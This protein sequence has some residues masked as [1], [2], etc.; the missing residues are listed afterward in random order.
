V[1]TLTAWLYGSPIVRL[2][3]ARNGQ[4]SIDHWYPEA[5]ERWGAGSPMMSLSMPIGDSVSDSTV[6]NFFDNL[7]PE[8]RRDQLAATLGLDRPTV[9]AVLESIGRDCAGAISVLD[10]AVLPDDLANEPAGSAGR[11]LPL[12]D[13]ELADLIRNL[14]RRPLGL[15]PTVRH[16]L[17]GV[18]GKLLLARTADG[19]WAQ[20]V[21]GEPSTH[22]LKPEP[23]DRPFG[24]AGNELLCTRLARSCGLTAVDSEM[25]DVKG[26]SVFVTS[27]FDRQILDD[28]VRRIHQEDLCQVFG[29]PAGAK[30]EVPGERLFTAT[31][32][33]LR[34]RAR[35]ADVV[36][37][38][39]MMT[40]NVAIGNTDA[41]C[42]NIAVLHH[43]DTTIALAPVYDV[44]RHIGP[45][46]PV[47]LGMSVNGVASI[48]AV[49]AGDLV[50]EIVTWKA[51]INERAARSIVAETLTAV[52]GSVEECATGVWVDEEIV[53]S[54]HSGADELL[55]TL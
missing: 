1:R 4:L 13:D 26:R 27:R 18:Q 29:R 6:T 38:A 15:G 3:E 16:S 44:A 41:H 22:I 40:F 45:G 9:F 46:L 53:D 14:P 25:L 17:A 51:R 20:P 54:I 30:Y 47:E 42:K 23:M 35:R 39:Q 28:G 55:S 36:R 24:D 49:T 48:L 32:S 37:L 21:G 5:I 50:E 19:R 11:L 2:V 43:S 8:V 12:S 33:I 52:R 10:A 7:L 31:A 34:A